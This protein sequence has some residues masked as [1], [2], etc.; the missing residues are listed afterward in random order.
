[1]HASAPRDRMH[2][3]RIAL[4][5]P[6]GGNAAAFARMAEVVLNDAKAERAV[7][8]GADDALDE[9]LA[10]WTRELVGQDA[11]D[12]GAWERALTAATRPDVG[13][14][15]AFVQAER[16][17]RRLKRVEA[18]PVDGQRA[19]EVLAGRLVLLVHDRSVLDED[20]VYSASLLV[21]GR[22]DAPI[23]RQIGPR[24]FLSPGPIEEAGGGAMVLDD[25]NGE[26][27][28]SFY[29]LRRRVTQTTTLTW[30]GP[31]VNV[32]EGKVP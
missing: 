9:A 12:E 21:F 18:L 25:A 7:Y 11:S 19:V 16:A 10:A 22:S 14:I 28:A 8:L 29:D 23:V 17:R 6:A 32:Q 15:D 31:R 27:Q 5:G 1:M 2:S 30:A 4:I 3:V 13:A 20:D 24:W 26:I